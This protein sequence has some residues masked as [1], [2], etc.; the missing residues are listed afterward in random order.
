MR[1]IALTQLF[2]SDIMYVYI[3]ICFSCAD[4]TLSI[5]NLCLVTASIR[6]W[7]HLGNDRGGLDVP[8]AVCDQIKD[9]TAHLTEEKKKE[10]LLIYY[11]CT[12]PMASWPSVAGALHRME[13]KTA[14]Q[15]VEVYLKDTPAGQSS[16]RDL[17]HS[18]PWLCTCTCHVWSYVPF[19]SLHDVSASFCVFQIQVSLQRTSQVCWKA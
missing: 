6:D 7:Y 4:P 12:M 9:S 18:F 19:S 8:P 2:C 5:N 1:F 17:Y 14:L 11:L 16:Y 13:E 15:A 10:A 3:P